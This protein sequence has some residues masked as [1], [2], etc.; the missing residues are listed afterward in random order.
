M[1]VST[2]YY[3]LGGNRIVYKAQNFVTG[4][5]VTAVIW[6]PDLTENEEFTLTE[7]S[8]GL[9]WFPYKFVRWGIYPMVFSENGIE[10]QFH[11][12]RVRQG[13]VI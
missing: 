4:L 5:T 3:P 9:Y 8:N 7:L 6:N 2:S 11:T 10:S 13:K 12:I 1:A